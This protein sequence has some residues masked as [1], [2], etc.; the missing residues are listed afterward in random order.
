MINLNNLNRQH[1][2]ITAEINSIM[3]VIGRGA[4]AIDSAGIALHIS[5]LAGQ[6][7]V[8]LMEEDRFLYPDLLSSDDKDIK[9]LTN[10]Y[11]TE[12]GNLANEYVIFKEK[13]N[14]ARKINMNMD[15][16]LDDTKNTMNALRKRIEKEE[17]GLYHLIQEKNL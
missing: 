16:F 3:D 9:E 7:K 17:K 15:K 13:Y 8:H 14:T 10:Q 1:N 12:M 5:K 6:L 2:T 11:I 4:S